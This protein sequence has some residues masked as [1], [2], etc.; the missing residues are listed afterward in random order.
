MAGAEAA[1]HHP[2]TMRGWLAVVRETGM[3]ARQFAELGVP[4]PEWRPI[5]ERSPWNHR[6]RAC[7]RLLRY[8]VRRRPEER[9]RFYKR[10]LH[11]AFSAG[12]RQA[13]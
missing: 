7:S 10:M 1:H 5:V 8:A 4:L 12:Y 6:L 11:A 13:G 2:I 3:S 9:E